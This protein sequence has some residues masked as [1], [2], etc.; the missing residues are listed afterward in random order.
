M[1]AAASALPSVPMMMTAGSPGRTRTT[2]NTSRETKR[3]V[4][5]S[6][7]TLLA[8]YRCNPGDAGYFCQ[9]TSE[10]SKTGSGR[11]F[12]MPVRPFLV[13]TSRGCM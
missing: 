7:A 1:R 4:A 9:A 3:R 6:A 10:R 13:A 8:R 12:Q 11:S 5:R 2:A